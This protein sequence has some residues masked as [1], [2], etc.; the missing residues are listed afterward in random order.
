MG[1][2]SCQR[3]DQVYG[4]PGGVGRCSPFVDPVTEVAGGVADAE[5]AVSRVIAVEPLVWLVS[6][7]SRLS[8]VARTGI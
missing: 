2:S 3:C 8:D 1:G 5:I 7:V 6:D 4:R